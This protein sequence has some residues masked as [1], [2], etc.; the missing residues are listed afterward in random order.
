[1]GLFDIPCLV[2]GGPPHGH[3]F[4]Y[5]HPACPE[6]VAWLDDYV[7]VPDSN[8]PLSISYD[9]TGTFSLCDV[10]AMRDSPPYGFCFHSAM[11]DDLR[12][13]PE[14][15]QYGLTCHEACYRFLSARMGYKLRFEDVWPLLKRSHFPEHHLSA[16]ATL[17]SDYG[18]I[19]K[20]HGQVIDCLPYCMQHV[21]AGWDIVRSCVNSGHVASW[22]GALGCTVMSNSGNDCCQVLCDVAA[23]HTSRYDVYRCQLVLQ[24]C[25]H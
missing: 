12:G 6:E 7:G 18:G 24:M 9:G 19:T 2:C 10:T 23:C 14:G 22:L 21:L 11:T 1:M 17:H 15:D 5:I 16:K 3:L 13:I 8:T 4:M 20:Y 25:C